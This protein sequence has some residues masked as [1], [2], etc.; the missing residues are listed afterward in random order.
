M[1]PITWLV[2]RP[3][4]VGTQLVVVPLLLKQRSGALLLKRRNLG[5]IVCGYGLV[6]LVSS[7]AGD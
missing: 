7:I 6:T 1:E 4:Y 3:V 5:A 2:L